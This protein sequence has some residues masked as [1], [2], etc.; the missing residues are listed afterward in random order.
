[1]R[2]TVDFSRLPCLLAAGLC[3]RRF[4]SILFSVLHRLGGSLGLKLAKPDT[5]RISVLPHVSGLTQAA[6]STQPA[7]SLGK[8]RIGQ[9]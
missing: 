1:M 8:L 7:I 4:D 2:G 3:S 5:S 9:L 6:L